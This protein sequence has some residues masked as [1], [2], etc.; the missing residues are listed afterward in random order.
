[1]VI[2]PPNPAAPFRYTRTG[3]RN[4]PA[5]LDPV[6]EQA[7][8]ATFALDTKS[9]S[10][11]IAVS[12]PFVPVK[13]TYTGN[14]A[15]ETGTSMLFVEGAKNGERVGA[16]DL[17]GFSVD[18]GGKRFSGKRRIEKIGSVTHAGGYGSTPVGATITWDFVRN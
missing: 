7:C 4:L 10:V 2:S 12:G 17:L 3:T 11:D 1:M 18:A 9:N 5:E 14:F 8:A 13:L 6:I 16:V 15:N